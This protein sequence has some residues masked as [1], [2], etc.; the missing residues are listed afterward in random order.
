MSGRDRSR[1]SWPVLHD[2][3]GL[4]A[5][6]KDDA[7]RDT[8]AA[9]NIC[10]L[11]ARYQR[12]LDDPRLVVQ[13]PAPPPLQPAQDLAPHRLMTLKLADHVESLLT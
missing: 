2:L 9:R 13:R 10:N 7:G 4:A 3:T 8:V 1:R 6:G 11:G 5:S 12:F